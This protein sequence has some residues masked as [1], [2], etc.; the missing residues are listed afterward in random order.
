[1]KTAF[2]TLCLLTAVAFPAAAETKPAPPQAPA[3]A[4]A[5]GTAAPAGKA[6]VLPLPP[7]FAVEA[8]GRIK[9][10]ATGASIVPPPGW[11][12]SS[13]IVQ[14]FPT[15]GKPVMTLIG[16]EKDGYRANLNIHYLPQDPGH[17][18]ASLGDYIR[19]KVSKQIPGWKEGDKGALKLG[20]KDAYAYS[21]GFPMDKITVRNIQYF[22][23]G[24]Q[25]KMYILTFT[26]LE[27]DY[28]ALKPLFLKYAQTFQVP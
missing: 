6:K 9:D 20:N 5:A 28:G 23:R 4:K 3:S 14:R 19:T 2:L 16:P 21:S 17:P 27:K 10:K 12:L 18:L 26:G 15:P 25:K 13:I 7:N 11:Q 24:N 22:V 1:M 8:G